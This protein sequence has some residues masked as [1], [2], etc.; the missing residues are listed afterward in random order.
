MRNPQSR[1]A[2][3]PAVIS[4]SNQLQLPSTDTLA[5]SAQSA[6]TSCGSSYN[7]LSIIIPTRGAPRLCDEPRAGQGTATHHPA[8]RMQAALVKGER[9]EGN[10][11]YLRLTRAHMRQAS[12]VPA[13]PNVGSAPPATT[14]GDE[15]GV[16]HNTPR[17]KPPVVKHA[18]PPCMQQQYECGTRLSRMYNT[19]VESKCRWVAV[20]YVGM[21]GGTKHRLG[22]PKAEGVR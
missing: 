19:A 15:A 16:Q 14:K 3:G 17:R 1:G 11:L 2:S 22:S 10:R 6:S 8:A 13:A 9:C 4:Q 12:R 5:S 20:S 21:W 7:D 18:R